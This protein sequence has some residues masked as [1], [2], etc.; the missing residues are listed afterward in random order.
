MLI[1]ALVGQ[2]ASSHK[3]ISYIIV[4]IIIL[5]AMI[6]NNKNKN[7]GKFVVVVVVVVGFVFAQM[8]FALAALPAQRLTQRQQRKTQANR[9]QYLIDSSICRLDSTVLMFISFANRL[10]IA[11]VNWNWASILHNS[12]NRP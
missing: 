7:G 12:I 4:D 10:L 8:A 5:Q 1:E 3:H 9:V 6:T 2:L 11:Y